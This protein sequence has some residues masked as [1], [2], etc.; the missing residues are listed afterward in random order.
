MCLVEEDGPRV[1]RARGCQDDDQEKGNVE[2]IN[3]MLYHRGG[4][5]KQRHADQRITVLCIILLWWVIGIV[6]MLERADL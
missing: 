2:T 6:L 3:L 1:K 5:N 4:E